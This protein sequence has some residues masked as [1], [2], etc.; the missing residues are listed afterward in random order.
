M[1]DLRETYPG[2]TRKFSV[3]AWELYVKMG[4]HQETQ[5][6]A[7]LDVTISKQGSTVAGLVRAWAKAVT[8]ALQH[9]MPWERLQAAF[10]GDHFEPSDDE[11]RSVIDGIVREAGYMITTWRGARA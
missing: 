9:G 4:F 11:S 8:F 5:Q 1:T 3:G 6:P 7:L 10:T 2:L